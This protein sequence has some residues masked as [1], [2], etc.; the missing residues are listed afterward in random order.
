MTGIF[1]MKKKDK[2]IKFRK[3]IAPPTK[4][5]KSKKDKQTKK[6]LTKKELKEKA[7]E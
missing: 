2:P 4:I 3:P 5:I 6:R 1:Q 7:N